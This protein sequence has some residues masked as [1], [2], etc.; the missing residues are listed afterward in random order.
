[1]RFAAAAFVL[2]FLPQ[3]PPAD[4][5]VLLNREEF[6]GQLQGYKR[7]GIVVLSE[8]SRTRQIPVDEVSRLYFEKAPAITQEPGEKLRLQY[9]GLL[10]GKGIAYAERKFTIETGYGRF[11]IARSDAKSVAFAPFDLAVPELKDEK[12]DVF[13]WKSKGDDKELKVAYGELVSASADTVVFKDAKGES[14]EVPR[15]DARVVYFHHEVKNRS[16][17]PTGWFSKLQM[18]NGDKLVGVLR[19]IEKDSVVVF[20]HFLGQVAFKKASLH[21]VQFVQFAR[22]SVGNLIVCEQNG[23]RELDRG[24]REIW[25][26][27]VNLSYPWAARKIENG[28]VIIANTNYNTV[29]EVRPKDA[30][31]GEVVWQLDNL[32]YPYDVQRLENGNTLVAEYYANRVAEFEPKNKTVTWSSAKCNYPMGAQRLEN[33]NT[34]ICSTYSV[35]EINGKQDEVWKANLNGMRPWR[36]ERLDSGNTIIVYQQNGVVVEVD[37]KGREVWRKDGLSRPTAAIRL[38]DGNTLICEQGR[39][40]IVEIDPTGKEVGK[41]TGLNYPLH[42]STY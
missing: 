15:A 32:N 1:M 31:S 29:I 9:G 8:G 42:I 26:Y 4:R 14:V 16:E 37:P 21:S 22:M 19:S 35:M 40:Q 12:R 5:V 41:I 13:L 18:K 30:S 6:A 23:V 2:F 24:G 3:D 25:K 34:L 28:N 36:A 38:D 39:H 17:V 27:Q 33:G 7:E 10:T 11:A 20:S